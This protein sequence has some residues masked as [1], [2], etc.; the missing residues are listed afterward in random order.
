[1]SANK[2]QKNDSEISSEFDSLFSEIPEPTSDEDISNYLL[3]AGYDIVK[4]KTEGLSFVKGLIADNW[5]FIDMENVNV[6]KT[7][8]N[9]I[10]L[11]N[12]W[13]RTQLF[14]AIGKIS[15]L[16]GS[17]EVGI[18]LSFRNLEELSNADLAIILQELEYKA[19]ANG[20]SLN[21]EK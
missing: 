10:P 9:E 17:G 7:K 11:H 20:F 13:D 18:S 6:P 12:N 21:G 19:L 1:M 8:L 4:L 16:L 15:N 3:E 14:A 5:R 2:L